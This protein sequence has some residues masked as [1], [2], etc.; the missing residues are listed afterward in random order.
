VGRNGESGSNGYQGLVL[1]GAVAGLHR[2]IPLFVRLWGNPVT[3]P[4]ISRMKITDPETFRKRVVAAHS[5]SGYSV[6]VP[7]VPA[8][9][10]VGI[11]ASFVRRRVVAGS[12]VLPH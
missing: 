3:G 12:L 7:I 5:S 10:G 6:V 1:A 8:S 11:P 9:L 4:L 2:H